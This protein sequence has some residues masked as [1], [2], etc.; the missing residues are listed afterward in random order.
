MLPGFWS[1]L[2]GAL[3]LCSTKHHLT[4]RASHFYTKPRN[5]YLLCRWLEK[6]RWQKSISF[7]LCNLTISRPQTVQHVSCTP[8]AHHLTIIACLPLLVPNQ[9]SGMRSFC[10][11]HSPINLKRRTVT[12]FPLKS[13]QKEKPQSPRGNTRKQMCPAFERVGL[14]AASPQKTQTELFFPVEPS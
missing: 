5:S 3:P 13:A 14:L 1:F 6:A 10:L 7:F 4:S 8:F 9:T 2:A 11:R 12:T